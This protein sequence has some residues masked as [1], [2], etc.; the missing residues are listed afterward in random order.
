MIHQPGAM[1]LWSS[2]SLVVAAYLPGRVMRRP[3]SSTLALRPERE[4][5][6]RLRTNVQHAAC[7]DLGVCPK[8][9]ER[10]RTIAKTLER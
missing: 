4:L 5:T 10:W 8:A 2:Y 9:L 3:R 7:L 6:R 1:G